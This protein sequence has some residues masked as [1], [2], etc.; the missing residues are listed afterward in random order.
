MRLRKI[1]N[2]IRYDQWNMKL[3]IT[4]GPDILINNGSVPIHAIN[5]IKILNDYYNIIYVPDPVLFKSF[6]KNRRYVISRKK[7]LESQGIKIINSF[8]EILDNT[9][10]YEE[11]INIYSK[12]NFDFLFDLEYI[13]N[14]IFPDVFT[15]LLSKKLDIKFGVCLFGLGDFDLHLWHYAYSTLMLSKNFKILIYRIYHYIN[16]KILS[17]KL[18]NSK[19]L[20]FIA[21]VNNNYDENI[22]LR[23]KNIE[24]LNPSNGIN[25]SNINISLYKDNKKDN[26]I[27]FF[28]RLIYNK[29]IFD[30]PPILKYI[31][32]EYN[33]HLILVGKFIYDKEKKQFFKIINKY[34]LN[35]RIIYRGYLSD[36]DL[37]KEISTSKLMIYPS[38]SDS[39]SLAISQALSLNT[40]VVAYNIAGLKI[41]KNFNA[42]KL[43]KEFDYKSMADEAVKILKMENTDELFDKNI[44]DFLTEHTW[45]NVAM[46]YRNIIEK[47]SKS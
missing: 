12:E 16:R 8:M 32:K 19:N 27:I 39:F 40:P 35:D 38:H 41:Y 15:S 6:K 42:V 47:Y 10:N 44:D 33:T 36:E 1:N 46:Q 3:G 29:G 30:I 11:I 7:Y 37:Y 22:N 4:A 31:I 18:V 14:S 21:M 25:N 13:N 26:K 23:F 17:I 34:K 43:V 2:A 9:Y 24:L 20:V 45:Y 28:A 5:V